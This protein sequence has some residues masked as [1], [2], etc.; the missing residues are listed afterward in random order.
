MAALPPDRLELV[1]PFT[2]YA[3]NYFGPFII[4]ESPKELKWYGVLF[5]CMASRDVHIEVAV[6]LET[7]SF[8]NTLRRFLSRR[9]PIRQLRINQ[10]TNFIGAKRELKEARKELNG[11]CN[12]QRIIA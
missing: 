11:E 5:T 7:D 3:V 10:G 4:K 12:T 2:S 6:S 1:P 8:I 9:G